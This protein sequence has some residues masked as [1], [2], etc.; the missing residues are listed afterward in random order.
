MKKIFKG[1]LS[2]LLLLYLWLIFTGCEP[3]VDTIPEVRD[4]ESYTKQNPQNELAKDTIKVMTWNIRFGC[5]VDVLWFGDACGDRTVLLKKEIEKN[6]DAVIY[7]INQL[8]PDVL[9]L[10]EV[11]IQS[12]RSAYIDQMKYIMDRTYF[13]YGYY[14]TN[15]KSQF[16]PSDGLGRMDEGNAILS[17]W[18][19]SEGTL[20]PLPLRTDVDALTKYFY[21]RESV[22]SGLIKMP[23]G[24]EFYAINTHLSAFST[25]DT[26]LR[27]L[28]KYVAICDSLDKTGLPI[29]TGGD[30]NLIPPNST[31]TDYCLIDACPDEHFHDPNAL[32]FHKDGSD[33]T[34]EISWLY[35]LY[36]KYE[37]SLPLN[38]YISDQSKYYSHSTDPN[39]D[40]NRTLDY[41]FANR[42]FVENSHKVWQEFRKEADHA[43]ITASW[44]LKK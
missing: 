8:R 11:D 42:P 35:E 2:I 43:A 18:P 9:L 12:K 20:H 33:Y 37:S 16:I 3:F 34:P 15:W 22:L 19:M 10:Q 4:C 24:K 41:L 31:I 25:D 32:P 28:Q 44:T 7:R 21:V 23:D 14:G 17:V 40:W 36:D 27:Q 29:V 39:I 5:G 1:N 13:G 38:K 6:L 30:F 26:K